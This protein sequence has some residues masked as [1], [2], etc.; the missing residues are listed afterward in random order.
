MDTRTRAQLCEYAQRLHA[1]GWVANHEGNASVRLGPG[2]HLATPTATSKARI[3]PDSLIVVDDE[4]RVVAGRGKPFG[5]IGLHLAVYAAR[6]DVRAVLHAHPPTATG[7]AVAGVAL[8][9]PLLAEAVV[10]LG[11]VPTV[12]WAAPGAPAAA[13]LRPYLL[14][15]DACLLASHGVLAW[16]DDLEQAYLRME[17]VEQL[18]RVALIARQLGGAHELPP[19]ALPAL[20]EARRKAFPANPAAGAAPSSASPTAAASP[21]RVSALA[22]PSADLTRI[23]TEEV[24]RLLAGKA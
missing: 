11:T 21:A 16:G 9:R 14:R 19:E 5:E 13:A 8:D 20:L 24:T 17:Q 15:C 1:R 3:T 7:F 18:A 23:I 2:R 22:S 12:P 4:G 6:P 10:S